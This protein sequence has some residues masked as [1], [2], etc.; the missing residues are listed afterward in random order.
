MDDI[1]SLNYARILVRTKAQ[2]KFDACIRLLFEHGSCDVWVKECS[3]VGGI[4]YD[5]KTE[6]LLASGTY[7][8]GKE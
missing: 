4:R 2:N 8:D 6:G 1:R 3:F 7:H 5:R